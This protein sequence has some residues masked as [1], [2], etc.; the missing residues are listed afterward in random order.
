MRQL[1]AAVSRCMP[2][3]V[4]ACMD[5][6]PSRLREDLE[7]CVRHRHV[8][9][10]QAEADYGPG[11]TLIWAS[12]ANSTVANSRYQRTTKTRALREDTYGTR[13]R[14]ATEVLAASF[15]WILS[16][17][18]PSLSRVITY[19]DLRRPP[20]RL[21]QNARQLQGKLCLYGAVRKSKV[22]LR[23]NCISLADVSHLLNEYLD[24]VRRDEREEAMQY[25]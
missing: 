25:V 12:V 10:H 4:C 14:S 18:V 3:C 16:D 1:P 22:G 5:I 2:V 11:D 19:I 21:P 7:G 24:C 8:A 20:W 6:A 17:T 9:R 23:D 13:Y 15:M